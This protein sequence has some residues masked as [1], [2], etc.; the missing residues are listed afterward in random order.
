MNLTKIDSIYV[1]ISFV[2]GAS[3]VSVFYRRYRRERLQQLRYRLFAVRDELFLLVAQG[4]LDEDSY[5]FRMGCAFMNGTIKHIRHFTLE[6][7]AR[8]FVQQTE[9]WETSLVTERFVK[10][11]RNSPEE[12]QAVFLRF[13]STVMDIMSDN[14]WKLRVLLRA[15]Q[16]IGRTVLDVMRQIVPRRVPRPLIY[17]AY[18]IAEIQVGSF[19]RV[20]NSDDDFHQFRLMPEA[21]GSLSR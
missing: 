2:F 15:K 6:N 14:S 17:M 1:G 8:S 20:I 5:L 19:D 21:Q 10:E 18:Q 11:L 13:A 7:L 3:L 16:W 4:K 12:V 9:A